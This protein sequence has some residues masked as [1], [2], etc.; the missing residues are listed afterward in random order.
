MIPSFLRGVRF[1]RSGGMQETAG[2]VSLII[3]LDLYEDLDRCGIVGALILW[4]VMRLLNVASVLR[5]LVS[6]MIAAEIILPSI[7]RGPLV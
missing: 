1:S 7:C 3:L 4:V 5:A 2:I 6:D